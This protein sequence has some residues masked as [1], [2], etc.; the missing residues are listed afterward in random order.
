MSAALWGTTLL[1]RF[2]AVPE[3]VT[4]LVVPH[5]EHECDYRLQRK[6]QPLLRRDT[7]P[8]TRELTQS[9]TWGQ[10]ARNKEVACFVC[11]ALIQ[12]R[13]T[14]LKAELKVTPLQQ[15]RDMSSQARHNSGT[16]CRGAGNVPH[17]SSMQRV[18]V[19]N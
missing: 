14:E 1:E 5:R 6:L 18:L 2:P 16:S 7:E 17:V 10:T 11:F 15:K 12:S 3:Q 4:M 8:Y 19:R 13:Q 9:S